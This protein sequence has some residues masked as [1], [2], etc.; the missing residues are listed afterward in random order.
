MQANNQTG[1]LAFIRAFL[2]GYFM[3]SDDI[4]TLSRPEIAPLFDTCDWSSEAGRG[5]RSVVTS[6]C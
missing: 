5:M 2:H 1:K 4:C 3:Y 6:Y